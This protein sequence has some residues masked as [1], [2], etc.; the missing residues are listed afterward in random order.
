MFRKI[1]VLKVFTK[2][3]MTSMGGLFSGFW[4]QWLGF[5]LQ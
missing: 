5:Y 2:L 4:D 3:R 1:F